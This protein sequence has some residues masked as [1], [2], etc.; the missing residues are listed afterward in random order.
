MRIMSNQKLALAASVSTN[1]AAPIIGGI[2]LGYFLDRWL[3]TTP[4]M[5]LV[6]TI[7]GTVGGFIALIRT[8]NKINQT[9]DEE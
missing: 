2:L 3:H 9:K 5:F 6:F 4:W 1:L 7:L 8:V